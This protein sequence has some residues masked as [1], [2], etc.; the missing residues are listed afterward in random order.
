MESKSIS[1]YVDL[2]RDMPDVRQK[3][4]VRHLLVDILFVS[5]IGAMA[6]CSDYE[7]IEWFAIDCKSWFDKYLELPNGIPSHDTIERTF[8]WLDPKCFL[9]AFVKF[10]QMAMAQAGQGVIA[11]DGKT[12]RGTA[13]DTRKPLHI[14]SA[15]FSETKM[16]LGQ[17]ATDVKSNEIT[18]IPAL[19]EMLHVTNHIVTMDAMGTQ[20]DIAELIRNKKGDYVLALKGNHPTM[21]DEVV[22]FFSEERIPAWQEQYQIQH[23][24]RIE[25]GHGRNEKRDWY[26]TDHIEWLSEKAKWAGLKSIG[27]CERTWETKG[28]QKKSDRRYFLCSIDA[29]PHKF[30]YA[31]RNHWGI[32]SMHWTLD[33]TFNED[34][35]RNRTDY[36]AENLSVL[37]KF[38]YNVHRKDHVRDMMSFKGKRISIRRQMRRAMM[39]EVY[40][41]KLMLACFE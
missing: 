4:K 33:V 30:A 35:R 34:S 39:S 24:H 12:M 21:Q 10:T 7:E 36:S 2:F 19:L 22:L 23:V 15:W 1:T 5:I 29:D 17:V 28:G 14:V 26:I 25:K 41:E 11:I 6:G 38:A 16:V 20:K 31:T 3:G 27:M 32:E 13:D 37:L 9:Q 18:A 8:K 40:L